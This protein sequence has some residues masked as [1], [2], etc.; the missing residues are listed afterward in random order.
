MQDVNDFMFPLSANTLFIYNRNKGTKPKDITFYINKDLALM[1]QAKQFVVCKEKQYLE[2]IIDAY[3][4][5]KANG[6]TDFISD[7][8]FNYV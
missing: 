2:K 7:N 1:H 3:Q 8:I 4:Q 6:W 5:V